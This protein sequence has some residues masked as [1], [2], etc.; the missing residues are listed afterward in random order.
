MK[1]IEILKFWF[2]EIDSSQWWVQ[3][4]QFDRSS[5]IGLRIFTLKQL[6]VNYLDGD[7]LLMAD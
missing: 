3:D 4:E 7:K 2:A 6:D 5:L 1:H